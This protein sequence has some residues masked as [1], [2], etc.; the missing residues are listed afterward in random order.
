ML[1]K[2]EN[3]ARFRKNNQESRSNLSLSP[4]KKLDQL[5]IINLS[6]RSSI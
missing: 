5:E 1:L 3:I 6:V 2:N 4:Q